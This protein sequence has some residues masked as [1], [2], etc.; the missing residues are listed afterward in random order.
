MAAETTKAGSHYAG[1]IVESEV[2]I[3]RQREEQK[4]RG[5]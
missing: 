4:E 2:L 1:E 5:S 3:H